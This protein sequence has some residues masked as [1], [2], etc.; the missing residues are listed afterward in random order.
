MKV[1]K[2]EKYGT[3]V[4]SNTKMDELRKAECLCLN[5]AD[6][7]DCPTAKGLYSTCIYSDIALIVTRC[8]VFKS[9]L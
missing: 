7:E 5:C 2:V 1:E 6:M 4:F 8:P 3:E 9:K